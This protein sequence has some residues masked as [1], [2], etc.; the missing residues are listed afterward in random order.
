MVAA[1]LWLLIAASVVTWALIFWKTYE[2]LRIGRAH[3][4][5][6]ERF[7]QAKSLDNAALQPIN[8][9]LARI[10]KAG[11]TALD[12]PSQHTNDLAHAGAQQEVL[13]RSL[14][15]QVEREQQALETGLLVLASIGSTAPFVG[16]FGT[17]WGIMHALKEIGMK[18]SASLEVVAGPVGEALIATA[19]GIAAAVPAVLAYNYFLRRLLVAVGG[20]EHFAADFLHLAIRTGAR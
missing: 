14:R 12:N 5:F 2:H 8:A 7:W 15:Q 10:A 18:G 13:E 19:W 11:L 1:T 9:P 4:R 16:L 20:M 3:K 6:L 17:V